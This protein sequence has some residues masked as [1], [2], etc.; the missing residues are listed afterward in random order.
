[1]KTFGIVRQTKKAGVCAR[2]PTLL[3]RD[4]TRIPCYSSDQSPNRMNFVNRN[5]IL[6]KKEAF[7]LREYP[8]TRNS[9]F[10]NMVNQNYDRCKSHQFRVLSGKLNGCP[11]T[12]PQL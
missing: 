4:G 8:V 10:N 5:S 1:M 11:L 7:I 6:Y 2:L 3:M 12:C 9:L